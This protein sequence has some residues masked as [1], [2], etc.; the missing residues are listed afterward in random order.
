MYIYIEIY[1]HMLYNM[2]PVSAHMHIPVNRPQPQHVLAL[3]HP[4]LFAPD[5]R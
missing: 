1:I 4:L 3:Q 5:E 2:H